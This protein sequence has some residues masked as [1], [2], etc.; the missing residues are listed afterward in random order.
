MKTRIKHIIGVCLALVV[1]AGMFGA[2]G[3]AFAA[4]EPPQQNSGTSKAGTIVCYKA[5]RVDAQGRGAAQ[6]ARQSTG[7]NYV[8]ANGDGVC[9]YYSGYGCRSNHFTDTDGNGV[10]DYYENGCQAHYVDA[11][12]N[13]ICDYHEYG[14]QSHFVDANGNG[15]CDYHESAQGQG[16]NQGTGQGV[17][18]GTAQGAGTGGHHGRHGNRHH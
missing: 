2:A 11:D 7:S 1:V 13:G 18:Q 17:G 5:Q 12:G 10:C 3:T 15:V 4:P 6:G 9:D 16:V 14:C 8:D